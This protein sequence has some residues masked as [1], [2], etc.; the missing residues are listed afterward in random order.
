MLF[1]IPPATIVFWSDRTKT[2]VKCD[3]EEEL[4]DPEKGI[5]M[6]I[7]K[8]LIGD[9][10]GAYY[11][12][13]KHWLTKWDEQLDKAYNELNSIETYI[14]LV[15]GEVDPATTFSCI[16]GEAFVN[17]YIKDEAEGDAE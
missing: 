16:P 2:V 7:A 17:G 5:A 6:A 13:F 10:N 9:N 3:Y 11:N 1:S 8:K 12:V 15:P 4:Y 14:D